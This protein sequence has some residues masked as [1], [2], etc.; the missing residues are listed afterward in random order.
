MA[1]PIDTT[2]AAIKEVTKG[3]TPATPAFKFA[4]PIVGS[5]NFQFNM[6]EL[7]SETQNQNR[8]A[9]GIRKVAGQGTGAA[10]F[11]LRRDP[12]ITDFLAS[13]F[14]ASLSGS[15]YTGGSTD[16]TFTFEEIQVEGATKMYYRYRN[17]IATKASLTVDAESKAQVAFDFITGAR[18]T[19]TAIL[20]GATYAKNVK[21]TELV[22][23][24]VG[25]I[26]IAGLTG[27]R[28]NSLE[29]TVEQAR[30]ANFAVGADTNPVE[31][32]TGTN[33]VVKL[34]AKV[35]RKD[36]TPETLFM[37]DTPVAVSLPFGGTGAGYT[38]DFPAMVGSVPQNE[39]NGTKQLVTM[40]FTAQ[41]DATANCA[42]TFTLT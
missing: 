10:K 15:K 19:G 17:V 29:L 32:A 42:A 26:S 40:T 39:A 22:A 14:S 12:M 16:S 18:D 5:V 21:G 35:Y 4:E 1:N 23:K 25:T 27:V 38:F 36:L 20:T 41:Y 2:Y 34:V 28:Y 33:R 8:D 24:D 6:T 9:S 3:T 37:G 30:E 31:I 7:S 11:E 13:A